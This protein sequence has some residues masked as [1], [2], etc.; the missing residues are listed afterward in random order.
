MRDGRRVGGEGGE[1]GGG[2]WKRNE[3]RKSRRTEMEGRTK[4]SGM[5]GV[6]FVGV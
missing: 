3:R 1:K 5:N 2:G 6:H 4:K